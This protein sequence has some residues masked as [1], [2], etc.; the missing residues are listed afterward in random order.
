MAVFAQIRDFLM[1]NAFGSAV[2]S[3]AALAI[4]GTAVQRI[5]KSKARQEMKAEE[6]VE[7]EA[8]CQFLRDSPA[9]SGLEWRSPEAISLDTEIPLGRVRELLQKDE[10]FV[11][12]VKPPED[13]W[14]LR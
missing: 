3:S 2:A 6:A 14:R 4:V 11:K 13:K 7:V 12:M 1:D 8:I 9:K 10:H 5:Q